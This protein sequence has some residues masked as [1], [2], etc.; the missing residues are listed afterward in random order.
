MLSIRTRIFLIFSIFVFIILAISLLLLVAWKNKNA[1]VVE[2]VGTE[3][4]TEVSPSI[5]SPKKLV[6]EI[7]KGAEVKPLTTE[8]M[9]KN[10]AKQ[11]AK[12]FVERVATYSTDN[13]YQNIRDV[14]NLVTDSLWNE[15]AQEIKDVGVDDGEFIGVTAKV[16]VSELNEWG[17]ESASFNLKALK[18]EKKNGELTNYYD[19]Y[20]VEV[21][22]VDGKW[23]VSNYEKK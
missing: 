4:N 10:A 22:K 21:V 16:Y 17:G 18:T 2:P 20:F 1:E 7:P 19:D 12:I 13:A 15:L 5:V 9:E 14:K 11:L 3:L 6:T 8:E 23:L